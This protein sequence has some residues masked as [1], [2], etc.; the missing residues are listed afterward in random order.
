MKSKANLIFSIFYIFIVTP[1]LLAL[2]IFSNDPWWWGQL[3]NF[4]PDGCCC[5]LEIYPYFYLI[6]IPLISSV[7]SLILRMKKF[8]VIP[9]FMSL[10]VFFFNMAGY[11]RYGI[12]Y[13]HS[14]L[15]AF[16]GSIIFSIIGSIPTFVGSII[17]ISMRKL[18]LKLKNKYFS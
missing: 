1:I 10:L 6:I 11:I 13:D 17:G 18:I 8:I 4:C 2:T 9:I 15:W 12:S 16:I 5:P 14:F 7:F 3:K